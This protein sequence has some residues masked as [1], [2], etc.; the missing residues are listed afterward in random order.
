[1]AHAVM[2]PLGMNKNFT[3]DSENEAV[4]R[5]G[6]AHWLGVQPSQ[7]RGEMPQ[8]QPN[9]WA[10]CID[11]KDIGDL[12]FA[13]CSSWSCGNL[14][15]VGAFVLEAGNDAIGAVRC[16]CTPMRQLALWPQ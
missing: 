8:C 5:G 13:P 12:D 15:K 14:G 9:L 6:V 7:Q 2:I 1:M 10:P 4:E 11:T 16:A 3:C